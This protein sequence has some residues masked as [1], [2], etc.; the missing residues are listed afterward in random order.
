MKKDWTNAGP[1]YLDYDHDKFRCPICCIPTHENELYPKNIEQITIYKKDYKEKRLEFEIINIEKELSN[2]KN[3]LKR[4]KVK[5]VK[6]H[7]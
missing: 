2:K 6:K 1:V 4:I 7:L 3:T 5:K